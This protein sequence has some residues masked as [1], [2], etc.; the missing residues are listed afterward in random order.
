MPNAPL[1]TTIGFEA[2]FETGA[3]DVMRYL[4]D[5]YRELVGSNHLHSYHCDCVHCGNDYLFHGQTDSSCSG[6]I[7]T[8]VIRNWQTL[9]Q[10]ALILQEAACEVDAVPGF[11]SGFHVHIGH[12]QSSSARRS[13]FF[14]I[15]RFESTLIML[16]SGRFE[17]QRRNN[18]MLQDSLAYH[19]QNRRGPWYTGEPSLT[20][21]EGRSVGF[22]YYHALEWVRHQPDQAD[23]KI[24]LMDLHREQDRHSNLNMRTRFDTW[25]FRFWNSTRSAWR[26]EM[27]CGLS[28]AFAHPEFV[29][30]LMNT[31]G[32]PTQ[33]DGAKRIIA[34]LKHVDMKATAKLVERQVKYTEEVMNGLRILPQEFAVIE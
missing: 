16:A 15:A 30:F 24:G 20:Y 21:R 29:A 32:V 3:E 8:S 9:K 6:E 34:A 31:D 28:A 33:D 2:E 10:A 7:I 12:P 26:I 1:P 14:E 23:M 13:A 27:W 17:L 11:S 4:Y 18:R 25:E 5:N 22:G 19:M